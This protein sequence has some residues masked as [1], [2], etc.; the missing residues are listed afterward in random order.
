MALRVG[1]GPLPRREQPTERAQER[2]EEMM[3][4]YAAIFP[5]ERPGDSVT[6]GVVQAWVENW[7]VSE[8]EE[9]TPHIFEAGWLAER[10]SG[11][12]FLTQAGYERFWPRH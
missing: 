12:L 2:A 9:A 10:P 11:D 1:D 4:V 6:K 5:N 3:R 7:R 8:R